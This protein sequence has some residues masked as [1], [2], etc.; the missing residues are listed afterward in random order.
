MLKIVLAPTL[1]GRPFAAPPG[2]AADR[3]AVLR[4]ASWR[5]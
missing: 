5:W 1:A 4:A 3:A 2:V